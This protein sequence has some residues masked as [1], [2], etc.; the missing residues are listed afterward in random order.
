M[1]LFFFKFAHEN[2]KKTASKVAKPAQIQPKSQ[3]LFYKNLRPRDFSIITLPVTADCIIQIFINFHGPF[4]I[5]ITIVNKITKIIHVF[6][7]LII[8]SFVIW[9]ILLHD[10]GY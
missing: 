4:Q 1:F 10:I 6:E 5:L 2:M 3:F 9:S 7:N 8:I